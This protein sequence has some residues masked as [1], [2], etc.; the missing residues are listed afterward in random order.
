M[1]TFELTM[2]TP[3]EL[4]TLLAEPHARQFDEPFK[5][6]LFARAMTWY[7]RLARNTV[8]KNPLRRQ[9]FTR[10]VILPMKPASGVH[11]ESVD[12]ISSPLFVNNILFDYVGSKDGN[13]PSIRVSSPAAI[14]IF[15]SNKYQKHQFYFSYIGGK[16][17]SYPNPGI[18]HL[19]VDGLFLHLEKLHACKVCA[20]NECGEQETTDFWNTDMGIPGDIEQLIIAAITDDLRQNRILPD[21]NKDEVSVTKE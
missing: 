12:V 11:A 21:T 17:Q 7:S 4:T 6:M 16:V 14:K 18:K 3:N 15:K 8:E 1:A 9:E 5:L 13:G 19:R 10:T 2:M 20:C